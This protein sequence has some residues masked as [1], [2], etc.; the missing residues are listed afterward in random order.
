M[1]VKKACMSFETPVALREK[2][3]LPEIVECVEPKKRG[4][5]ACPG[6]RLFEIGAGVAIDGERLEKHKTAWQTIKTRTDSIFS[7]LSGQL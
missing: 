7:R 6:C 5:S 1:A 2:G 3:V 4:Q